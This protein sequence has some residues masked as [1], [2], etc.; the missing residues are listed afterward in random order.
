[1]TFPQQG[2]SELHTLQSSLL[3]LFLLGIQFNHGCAGCAWAHPAASEFGVFVLLLH[4][5]ILRIFL[6]AF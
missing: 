2:S 4:R 5:V 3:L 6:H 1:V